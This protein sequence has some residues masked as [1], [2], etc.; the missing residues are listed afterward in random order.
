MLTAVDFNAKVDRE[1]YNDQFLPLKTGLRELQHRARGLKIPIIVLFEGWDTAGKGDAIQ[2]I[3]EMLD[4]RGFDVHFI[5]FPTPEEKMYPW[6]RRFWTKI[7]DRGRMSF[8]EHSWY[9][10]VLQQ[11]VEALLTPK[12]IEQSF[13]DIESFENLLFSDGYLVIKYWLHLSKKQ[14]RRRLKQAEEDPYRRFTVT[15]TEWHHHNHYEEYHQAVEEMLLRTHTERSPWKIIAAANRRHRRL[16]TLRY[17]TERLTTLIEQKEQLSKSSVVKK[18]LQPPSV[19]IPDLEPIK[20]FPLS[21]AKTNQK[22]D[23]DEYKERLEEGQ[24]RIRQLQQKAFLR[25]LPVSILFEGWDAAGKG[26]S[27]KRMVRTLD[28]RG[29]TVVPIGKPT[30]VELDHHY[31]WRFWKKLPRKGHITIFDRSWYGR[32]LVER[33]E[34]FAKEEEW[35]R[36]YEE[37]NDFERKLHDAE[38]VQLKFWINITKEEQLVRFKARSQDPHKNWKLTEEDWRNRDKWDDY[39]DAVNEMIVRTSTEIAPWTIVSGNDKYYARVQ[40]LETVCDAIERALD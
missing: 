2:H 12:D 22:L 36:A 34:G 29:Y 39:V 11:K 38:M 8:F 3:T 33:V 24:I 13:L 4:P 16:E 37:I 18:M 1:E 26:G 9:N 28:P 23:S 7:P 5:D 20:K 27:I 31:L 35:K 17:L 15:E 40:V 19:E 6:L 21:E 10:R 30:Q 32:V 14:Q 25:K